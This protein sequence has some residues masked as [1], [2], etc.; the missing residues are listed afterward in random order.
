MKRIRKRQQRRPRRQVIRI[1][2]VQPAE[3]VGQLRRNSPIYLH[4]QGAAPQRPTG[5][6]K[7]SP[8]K[9]SIPKVSP[10]KVSPMKVS[11]MK[12]SPL[13]VSIPKVSP[14]KVSLLKVSPLKVSPLAAFLVVQPFS[15]FFENGREFYRRHR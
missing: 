3:V 15:V 11:P 2:T 13:K 5:V 9:V 12:V 1:G 14:L 6:I 4:I 7:V 10:M 8:L